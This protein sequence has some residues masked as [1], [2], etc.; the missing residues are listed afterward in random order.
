MPMRMPR[1]VSQGCSGGVSDRLSACRAVG[2]VWTRRQVVDDVR[3]GETP[4]DVVH[5]ADQDLRELTAVLED[6]DELT[7]DERLVLLRQAEE[8]VAASLEGLDGL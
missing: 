7:V 1:S 4:I 5:P 6:S 8:A 2:P 3:E